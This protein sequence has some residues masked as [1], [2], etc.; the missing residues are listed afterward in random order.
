V[1][2]TPERAIGSRKQRRFFA[3]HVPCPAAQSLF[4]W[5][6]TSGASEQV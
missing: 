2:A 6:P 4:V 5:H 1:L 3:T